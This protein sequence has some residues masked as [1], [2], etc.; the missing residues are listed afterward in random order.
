[1]KK[2]IIIFLICFIFISFLP[3]NTIK[4]DTSACETEIATAPTGNQY[5]MPENI[6][7]ST[8]N[9]KNMWRRSIRTGNLGSEDMYYLEQYAISSKNSRVARLE[10][11]YKSYF[12]NYPTLLNDYWN[13]MRTGGLARNNSALFKYIM[14]QLDSDY[15]GGNSTPLWQSE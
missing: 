9:V 5:C 12:Q 13:Y 10:N 14:G 7:W 1:M 6:F 4:A 8:D 2:N 3:I 11:D 15:N